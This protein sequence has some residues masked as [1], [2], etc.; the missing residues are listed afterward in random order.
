PCNPI[1]DLFT[2]IQPI[3]LAHN[4]KQAAVCVF[5]VMCPIVFQRLE[6]LSVFAYEWGCQTNSEHSIKQLS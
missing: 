2:R 5:V 4:G 3:I 1:A 6:A